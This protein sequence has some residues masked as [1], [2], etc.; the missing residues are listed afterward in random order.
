MLR[1]VEALVGRLR[2]LFSPG[3][4]ASGRCRGRW[5]RGSMVS[6]EVRARPVRIDQEV[7][8]GR[9][10]RREKKC[11]CSGCPFGAL[12][13]EQMLPGLL[14]KR[15]EERRGWRFVAFR[16]WEKKQN[17]SLVFPGR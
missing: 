14:G 5:C 6:G 17:V 15:E 4:G 13:V 3:E 12:V 9:P 2:R 16:R 8:L 7:R 1:A 11:H 10:G